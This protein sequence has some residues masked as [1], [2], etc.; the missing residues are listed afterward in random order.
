MTNKFKVGDYVRCIKGY[1]SLFPNTIHKI[2]A[3]SEYKEELDPEYDFLTDYY[4][5]VKGYLLPFPSWRFELLEEVINE[6]V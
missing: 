3:I 2:K 1:N 4:F 5:Y 6:Q